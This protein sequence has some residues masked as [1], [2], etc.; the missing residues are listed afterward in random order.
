[1]AGNQTR[2]LVVDGMTWVKYE[3]D[4]ANRMV[5]VTKDDTGQTPLQSFHYGSTNARKSDSS[6]SGP[7]KRRVK[8]TDGSR[9][10]NQ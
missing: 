4:A 5:V 10:L 9:I 7:T 2:A 6:T 3:Y 8:K 1:M